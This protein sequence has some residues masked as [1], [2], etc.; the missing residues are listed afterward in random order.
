[1]SVTKQPVLIQKLDEFI[2]KYYKNQLIKGSIYFVAFVLVAFLLIAILEFFGR[3]NSSVRAFFFFSF[4]AFALYCLI[5]Y[6]ILPLAHI[7]RIGKTISYTQAADIIGKH[8]IEVKDSLLNTLQLQELALQSQSDNSLLLAAIQQKTEQLRPVPFV[9]A[10]NFRSNLHYAKYA[11]IPLLV[12]ALISIIAPS[13]ISDSGERILYYKQTFIPQAPFTFNLLNNSLKIEQ[14]SDIDIHVRMSGSSIP[15]EVF[16]NI[17]GNTYKMQKVD[18][19]N[20]LHSLKN[21]QKTTSFVFQADEF[22]S[23]EYKVEVAAK[24][25]ILSYQ[26]ACDYPAYLGKKDETLNN[27]GDITIPAG[28]VLN[29]KFLTKQTDELVLGFGDKLSVAE[30][31]DENRFSFVKKFFMSSQYFIRNSNK[32]SQSYDSLLYN[33]TVVPDAFPDITVDEKIDSVSNQQVYFIGD[34]N[35]DHGFSKLAF[36]Y[37]FVKSDDKSKTQLPLLSKP[38]VFDKN[39]TVQRFYHYFNVNEVNVKP[40]DELEYYFEVWDNDGVYGA[41]SS[42]SKTMLFKSATINELKEK[43]NANSSALKDK[44]ADALKESRDLQ[45]DL[46]DLERKMLEK[47]ELTWEEKQKAEKLLERQKEL[48]KKIDELQKDFKQNNKQEEQFKEEQERILEKQEQLEKRYKELITDEMKQ[49][50]KRMEDMM[51][52]Q[53]KDLLK[54][55]M[56]KMQLNNKDVEKELD[57]MLEMYKKIELEKKLEE[58]TD[59]LEKLAEKQ[60]DLAKKTEDKNSD[61]EQLKEEQKKL[62]EEFKELQKDL[63]EME[64]LNEKLEDKEDLANTDEEQKDTEEQM[65]KS[66]EELNKGNKKKA[67]EAEKKAADAMKKAA[68]KMKEKQAN[69]EDKQAEIDINALREIL[70]NLV[71]LS[72]QQEDLMQEFGRINGYNPQYVE[73]GKKQKNLNDNARMVEDS[74][75]ELSK[76]VPEMRSFVNREVSKMNDQMNKAVKGFATRDFMRTRSYQQQAMT[77]ANNLAVMLSDVLKQLQAQQQSEQQGEGKGKK[78]GKPKPGSGKGSGKGKPSMSQLKKMQEELNK[79]LR[80][81]LNKNGT[82]EKP[83]GKKPGGSQG[84]GGMGSEGFARMAAQQMAIRQQMQKMLQQMDAKEKEQ[85]GGGKQLGELQKMMEQT[86]KELFNKRLTSETLMRQQDILT[87]LLESE[88]AE[89]KQEQDNKREAEQAKEKERS[90]PTPS[91]DKYIKQKNKETELIKTVPVGMQPYYIEKSKQ[92]LHSIEK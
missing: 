70:E 22:N 43:S 31:K 64:K 52:L 83:N 15:D 40:G 91:F 16:I 4:I 26:V 90:L 25:L 17:D 67:A 34:I 30:K 60:E 80:E 53:N 56:E 79:Q 58:A 42:K 61:K 92:Y 74:I 7:Y 2:R 14:F 35:D 86:E 8:F 41:K 72:K 10:I 28:T 3:Y 57:R 44:M 48:N 11:A 21:I 18:K 81:G 84:S 68:Q 27:P 82:G 59:K 69:E 36:H 12:F 45:K 38:L 32:E 13:M 33:V 5:R 51:K 87:R 54:N 6:I 89:R 46:K 9:S 71:E 24:P 76:R 78:S 37:R 19:L 85:M 73:L 63:K 65:D 20:F 39:Q 62:N 50:M 55:E 29:W 1:M 75:L 88:K 47:K 23:N 66:S 49:L 77:N